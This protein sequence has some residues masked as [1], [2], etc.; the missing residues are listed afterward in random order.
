[1]L[2]V[3]SSKALDVFCGPHVPYFQIWIGIQSASTCQCRWLAT[4]I[5]INYSYHRV[6]RLNRTS[7][8]ACTSSCLLVQELFTKTNHT[9]R[10]SELS[11]IIP[12]CKQQWSHHASSRLTG[13]TPNEDKFSSHAVVTRHSHQLVINSLI[14]HRVEHSP[15]PNRSKF[16]TRTEGWTNWWSSQDTYWLINRIIE[17]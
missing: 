17:I 6:F 5:P 7:W 1:M 14:I 13:H 11:S 9:T 12:L 4:R 15:T 2:N 3:H 10:V 8:K 16:H